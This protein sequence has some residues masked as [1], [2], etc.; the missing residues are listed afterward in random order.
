MAA[1]KRGSTT[2]AGPDEPLRDEAVAA[3]DRAGLPVGAW[4]ERAAPEAPE[5]GPG[6]V[7]PAGVE[8]GELE[9]MVRRVVTEELRPLREAI[10][11]LEA[12]APPSP[13]VGGSPV[14]LMR[15]RRRRHRGR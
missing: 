12:M 9:A 1:R 11:R 8:F 7:S 15:E 14:G 13:S 10:A 4:G 2:A 3:A 6:P 5:G